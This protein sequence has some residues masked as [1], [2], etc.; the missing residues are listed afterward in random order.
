MKK[1]ILSIAFFAAFGVTTVCA[2]FFQEA[3]HEYSAHIGG[4]LG[5]LRYDL[6]IGS[7]S[8][9]VGFDFGVGYTLFLR[10]SAAVETGTIRHTQLGIHTG[11]GIALYGAKTAL[12]GETI[13]TENLTD[14][15][16]DP[17][18]SFEVN[19]AALFHLH[20]KVRDFEET[21]RLTLLTIPIMAQYEIDRYYFMGGFRFGVPIG[22][23][24]YS[25]NGATI[26]NAADYYHLGGD[27]AKEPQFVGLGDGFALEKTNDV[28][29]FD[30]SVI[31]SLEAGVKWRI[32]EN[33]S[34]YTGAYFDYGLNNAAK[35]FAHEPFVKY[36]PKND[37]NVE[38]FTANSILSTYQKR[39][40]VMAVGV[41]VR[42]G[43]I[44]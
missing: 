40:N 28:L 26:D 15:D 19:Q 23:K 21:Q 16:Y 25:N 4:G 20:S 8:G 12:N 35:N 33:I 6:P 7:R 34:V 36:E 42:V 24:Y 39:V 1:S 13:V 29:K 38:K 14:R 18:A 10:N 43:Y 44:R 5:S 3:V 2:Q 30:V 32:N 31:L 37:Y 9:G 41:K 27:F 22:G 11:L 17:N